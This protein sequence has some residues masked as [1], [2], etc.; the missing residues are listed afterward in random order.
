MT[1]LNMP[2][3]GCQAFLAE[4][5]VGILSVGEPGRGPTSSPVWYGYEPGGPVRITAGPDS[6]KVRLIQQAGRASLC[7]QTEQ[8]PYCYVSVEGPV[9]IV[10]SDVRSEQRVLAHRYLGEKLGDRYLASQADGLSDEVLL[11][12]H[13]ERWW[14]RDF[15]RLSLG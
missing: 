9:E 6:R 10:D 7:V 14:S 13:P 4:V 15:S 5:H 3:S 12:L 2:R 11:H 1:T 8:L